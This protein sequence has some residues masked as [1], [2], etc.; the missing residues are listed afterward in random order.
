MDKQLHSCSIDQKDGDNE[1][2][3][4]QKGLPLES[5]WSMLNFAAKGVDRLELKRSFQSI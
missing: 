3:S 1:V 5:D 4:L 2:A